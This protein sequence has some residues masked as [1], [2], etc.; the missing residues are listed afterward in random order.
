MFLLH[1]NSIVFFINDC[2]YPDSRMWLF[3]TR[4]KRYS[5]RPLVPLHL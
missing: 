5:G 4:I 1:L 2:F 3:G